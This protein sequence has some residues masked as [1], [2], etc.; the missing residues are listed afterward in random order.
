VFTIGEYYFNTPYD[1]VAEWLGDRLNSSA[2]HSTLAVT[3][4]AAIREVF[5]KHTAAMTLLPNVR[6]LW[7]QF[8]PNHLQVCGGGGAAGPG[9]QPGRSC[10]C[11]ATPRL[12][13]RS[14]PGC[15]RWR[16]APPGL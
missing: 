9:V 11:Q 1:Q 5:L 4:T 2:L 16:A 6:K 12:P 7:A 8:L 14:L 15:L 10:A 13:G 3:M